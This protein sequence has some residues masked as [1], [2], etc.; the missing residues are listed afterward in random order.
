LT[1]RDD[2]ER[3]EIY[4]QRLA[5]GLLN[6]HVYPSLEEAIKAARIILMDAE[7]DTDSKRINIIK[8][9]EKEMRPIIEAGFA[10]TTEGL[11]AIAIYEAEFAKD[12]IEHYQDVKLKSAKDK[13]ESIV[14]GSVM[15]LTS[16]KRTTSNIWE[17][18]VR[19]NTDSAISLAVGEI[20]RGY[21]AQLP[22]A[23]IMKN[24][25]ETSLIARKDAEAL[26]RTGTSFFTS[27]AR[28]QMA[29][30]NANVVTYREYNAVFDNRTTLGCRALHGKRWL[31]T[32]NDYVRT[33]RHF[34]CRS[35]LTLGT[36]PIDE[37][38]EG[39]RQ[40]TSGKE[41]DI[42]PRR[43][44]KYRGKK[45]QDIFDVSPIDAKKSQDEWLKK[46]P[47]WFIEDSLGETRAKLFKSGM[48]LESFSDVYGR[49]LKISELKKRDAKIFER[50][51]L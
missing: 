40:A 25:R 7:I 20:S 8:R 24:V 47:D 37:P 49:E 6:S 21:E 28:E 2:S 3:R 38:A 10:L 35:F 46:Q 43:K 39:T 30:L 51:G 23:T 50:A 5:T 22:K 48:K 26:V 32:D 16:G 44:L 42:N 18:Y 13:A 9:I 29:I 17:A 31:I 15:T 41:A 12:L 34:G 33:P 14:K 36:G 45:D 4:L 1:Y 11:V 19:A 27:Q